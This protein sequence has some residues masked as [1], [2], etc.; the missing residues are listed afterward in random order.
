MSVLEQIQHGFLRFHHAVYQ[1][2]HG[3]I[4]HRMLGVPSLMLHT[5]GRRTGQLRIASL[6]YSPDGDRY[7]V[8]AS[9]GGSDRPPAWLHNVSAK[10]DVEIQLGRKRSPATARVVEVGDPDYD[11]LW[12]L[13]NENNHGRYD[14]YQAKTQRRIAMVVL[15][16]TAN[17]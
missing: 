8:T 13:V 9:N 7:V 14:R 1:G 17:P 5:T 2:T 6:V 3:L 12:H 10:P 11:R 4:G 15:T 16:P